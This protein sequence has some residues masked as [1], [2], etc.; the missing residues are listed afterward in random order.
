MIPL[1]IGLNLWFGQPWDVLWHYKLAPDFGGVNR[2]AEIFGGDPEP[3]R[4]I[5][6]TVKLVDGIRV[7]GNA[8][9]DAR[10]LF[11]VRTDGRVLQSIELRGNP[12][13]HDYPLISGITLECEKAPLGA[14]GLFNPTAG[15]AN[16][17]LMGL[18]EVANEKYL[19]EVEPVM[20]HLYTFEDELPHLAA[21]VIPEGYFGAGYDFKGPV[22][23]VCAATY[24]YRNG[25]ECASYIANSGMDADRLC[26]RTNVLRGMF[27]GPGF[28]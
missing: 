21:P 7:M 19:P 1:V 14:E 15:E 9:C 12:E 24:L 6:R 25:P 11:S 18:D 27:T 13:M 10:Y 20:R 16:V 5:E 8:S 17:R 23:A 26:R 22:V 4:E 28:G 3:R 2:D